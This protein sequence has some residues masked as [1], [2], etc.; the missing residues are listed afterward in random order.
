MYLWVCLVRLFA[1][2]QLKQLDTKWVHVETCQD[3]KGA[4]FCF[5]SLATRHC[6]RVAKEKN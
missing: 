6:L 5:L 1:H 2:S 3:F 4:C